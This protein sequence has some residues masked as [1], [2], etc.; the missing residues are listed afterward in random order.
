MQVIY[1]L[2]TKSLRTL[3]I[4]LA[5][6]TSAFPKPRQKQL[7]IAASMTEYAKTAHVT[8]LVEAL[9]LIA[10]DAAPAKI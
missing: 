8:A 5:L 1:A 3:T 10:K 7:W 4:I 6:T 2:E 9:I